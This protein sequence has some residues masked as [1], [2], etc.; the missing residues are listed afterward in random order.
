MQALDDVEQALLGLG[1]LGVT[2]GFRLGA[3]VQVVPRVFLVAHE[4]A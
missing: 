3:E 4:S 1:A 2:K